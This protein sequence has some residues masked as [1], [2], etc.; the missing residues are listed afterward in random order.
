M[1]KLIDLQ[2]APVTKMLLLGDSGSGKTG[3][4]MSLVAAGYNVRVLDLDNGL[5]VLMDY[6][7]NPKSIYRAARPGLW[8]A[9]QAA[10]LA[11]RFDFETVTDKMRNVNGKLIP[12]AATVWQRSMK[13]LDGWNE[14]GPISTWTPKDVLVIDTLTFISRAAMNFVLM[15]NSKL[16]ER[17][18]QS[19]WG[20]AQQAIE[21][22]LQTLYDDGVNCNVIVNCH[23]K[24]FGP[25]GGLQ[26]WYPET[27]GKA[28][29]PNI[30][31]YFNTV[32]QTKTSGTGA[33]E[34]RKIVTSSSSGLE[35]KT[36]CPMR[37]KP[38]YDL[39]TGLAEYFAEERAGAAPQAAQAPKPAEPASS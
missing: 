15:M 30:G 10:S 32:L 36:T 14:F 16:G 39:A 37:V 38:E 17:P 33:Q 2:T 31:R 23:M 27:L 9:E 35:L 6:F 24:L 7:T 19:H 34:R 5:Q 26:K 4:L 18:E 20:L 13:L 8:T 1:A 3:A 29:S 21:G 28:L 12:K 11:D 25:D 22:L